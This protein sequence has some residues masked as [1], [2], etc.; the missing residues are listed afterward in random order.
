MEDKLLLSRSNREQKSGMKYEG[1]FAAGLIR[2]ALDVLSLQTFGA[3]DNLKLDGFAFVQGFEALSL[4]GGVMN[5][6]ILAGILGN[7]TKSFLVVEPLDFATGHNF[8]L[9]AET[10]IKKDTRWF[11]PAGVPSQFTKKRMRLEIT[12][13]LIKNALAVNV[14]D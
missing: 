1:V 10:Q 14:K 13:G 11:P 2:G 12:Y 4:N 6:H 7:E 5:E 9:V 8:F 3:F